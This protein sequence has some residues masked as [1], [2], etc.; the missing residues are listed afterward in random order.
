MAT[1]DVAKNA[2]LEVWKKSALQQA[3]DAAEAA[4][5]ALGDGYVPVVEPVQ[6]A[7][8]LLE[9]NWGQAGMGDAH[10]YFG[11]KA[12]PGEP[13][14]DVT[15]HE[16]EQGVSVKQQAGFRAFSSMAECFEAHAR[17]LCTKPAYAPARTHAND[18]IAFAHAL[19]GVYAT[20]PQYGAKLE[21]IMRS[22]GLLETFGF[23]LPD[24]YQL[25][26]SDRGA[27][28]SQLLDE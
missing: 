25:Q 14:V 5:V 3:I 7:Q 4:K 18:P 24:V 16:V 11:I 2:N 19:T 26:S 15:T 23:A 12:L 10:N 6:V 9:S 8:F 22:R 20:D 21:S 13:S 17:L 1:M 28:T 27:M